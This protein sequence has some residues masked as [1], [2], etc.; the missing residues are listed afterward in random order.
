LKLLDEY[1]LVIQDGVVDAQP[2]DTA[3]LIKR[4]KQI[5]SNVMFDLWETLLVKER[6]HYIHRGDVAEAYKRADKVEFPWLQIDEKLSCLPCVDFI[7]ISSNDAS[8]LFGL[9]ATELDFKEALK[10]DSW[11]DFEAVCWLHGRNPEWCRGNI[12]THYKSAVDSVRRA[13]KAKTVTTDTTPPLEWIQWATSKGWELPD[14]ISEFILNGKI[15]DWKYWATMPSIK[16]FEA[17]CLSFCI[18]PVEFPGGEC[19]LGT[20]TDE[21]KTEIRKCERWLESHSDAWTLPRLVEILGDNRSPNGM[22]D[23]AIKWK[24][25]KQVSEPQVINTKKISDKPLTPPLLTENISTPEEKGKIKT[26][27]ECSSNEK[28]NDLRK[29]KI[30]EFLFDLWI[31]KGQ[32][33]A[34]GLVHAIKPLVGRCNCPVRKYHGWYDEVCVEWNHNAGS[35]KGSWGKK[36]FQNKIL[37][38]KNSRAK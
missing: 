37:E 33:N 22:K 15:I 35:D 38:F 34:K 5:D 12:E 11:T 7:E 18:D 24:P 17:A 30:N 23:A 26:G 31:E 32:P 27:R 6:H 8:K 2:I 28:N 14:Y 13:I 25:N 29:T 3:S 1:E 4:I 36:S 16:S 21:V 20:L 19:F 9:P 10:Q